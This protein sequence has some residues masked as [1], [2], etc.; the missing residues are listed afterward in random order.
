[1]PHTPPAPSGRAGRARARRDRRAGAW[2][3]AIAFCLWIGTLATID[4]R[5]SDP[6]A[7]PDPSAT[8]FFESAVRP[9]LVEHCHSCHGPAKA[10]AGL[11]LDSRAAVLAGGE[12]GPAI[13]LG[14]PGESLLID[15]INYGEL[16]QMPPKSKLEDAEIAA[17]TRWVA[18]GAPWPEPVTSPKGPKPDA[19][20]GTATA[21]FDLQ[22]RARHWSFQPLRVTPLPDVTDTAW[23]RTPID[24]FILRALETRGLQPAPEADRRTWLRRVTFDL[25]GLP[26]THAE[27][28]AFLAD[29]TPAAHENVVE[30]L[31][32]SPRYGERWARHWL[33]LVGF[34]E[35]SGHEFDYDIP[36]AFRYRDYI[37]RALNADLPYDQLVVEHIAGDLLESPRMHPTEG[38]NE[39]VLGT[40]FFFLGEGTH[41]PV[42]LRDDEAARIDHQIDVLAKTF[43]GLTVACA[44]CHDHKFDPI[45][46]ADYYALS[47]Y[48]KSARHQHA[49]IDPPA[50]LAARAA[51]LRALKTSLW[52]RIEAASPGHGAAEAWAQ[53]DAA[54]SGDVGASIVFEDFAGPTYSGWSLTGDAFGS[55]P[56]QAGDWLIH[57]GGLGAQRARGPGNGRGAPLANVPDREALYP[58]PGSG[59]RWPDQYRHRRLRE[60]P[61]ADLRPADDRCQYRAAGLAHPG[62]R[63]VAGPPGLYRDRRRRHGRLHQL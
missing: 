56:T 39:S 33:D 34:A 29:R 30:R 46:T 43:L 15:A 14:M 13:V 48:L 11:R 24:R 4:T 26:P 36:D 63:D 1:L 20:P 44:R 31:L 50:R 35:T 40:G 28:A 10:K 17:L 22:A 42:D 38:F 60:D 25:T 53:G 55:G 45:T 41:S 5:A 27:I 49:F 57:R 18:I 37:I 51:E 19:T 23:P 62:R 58:D 6:D 61:G 7:P 54:S 59:A 16:H 12:S 32:A 8:A 21:A 3:T 2:R 52:P 47:G 9:I